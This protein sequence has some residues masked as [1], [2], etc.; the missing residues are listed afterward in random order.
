MSTKLPQELIDKI[1]TFEVQ[2]L[3]EGLQNEEMRNNPAFLAKVRQFMKDN[4]FIVTTEIKGVK[5]VIKEI[6]TIPDLV[7]DE[8]AV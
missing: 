1:A 5:A 8:E 2:T 7:T 3:L 6:S 4:N